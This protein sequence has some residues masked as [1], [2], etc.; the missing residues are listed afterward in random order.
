MEFIHC[1]MNIIQQNHTRDEP[2]TTIQNRFITIVTNL[3]TRY[4][5]YCGQDGCACKSQV[6]NNRIIK[7]SNY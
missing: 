7:S 5:A 4:K 6:L 1:Q 3:L 2:Y